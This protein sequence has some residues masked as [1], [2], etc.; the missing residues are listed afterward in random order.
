MVL[1]FVVVPEVVCD[2][3]LDEEAVDVTV[4]KLDADAV[5]LL[6][7]VPE[8][9]F[10]E[11]AD[12]LSVVVPEL[13]SVFVPEDDAV[14]LWESDLVDEAELL[15]VVVLESD[16]VVDPV[17]IADDVGLLVALDVLELVCDA[18]GELLFE[19]LGVE[20]PVLLGEK[21]FVVL[22]DRDME[23][24]TELEGDEDSEELA[25]ELTL[26]LC[27][28]VGD[29][30]KLEVS[31]D[32]PD[33]DGE[34]ISH[35]KLPSLI[36]SNTLFIAAAALRHLVESIKRPRGAPVFSSVASNVHANVNWVP[37]N[38]VNSLIAAASTAAD[39]WQLV[40]SS[41]VTSLIK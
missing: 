25:L 26:W 18:V 21:V 39:L 37:G 11:L 4:D 28:D 36:A 17:D 30:V 12:V 40:A 22:S 35:G 3:V 2:N 33:V 1:L 32:V 34:V 19:W 38:S 5:L 24:D 10:V 27:V 23:L 6:E 8:V 29:V 41:D 14:V 16:P 31:V 20:L 15:G 13:D 9:D 7:E